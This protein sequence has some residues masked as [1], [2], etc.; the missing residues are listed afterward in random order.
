MRIGVVSDIHCNAAALDAALEAMS[1]TVEEVLVA[2]D[3][4]YEYRYSNEVV[5]TIRD[6]GF[7]C[8]LGNHEMVLLSPHGDRARSAEGVDQA[9]VAWMGTWP[10]RLDLRIGGRR[11]T[12]VHASPWEPYDRYLSTDDPTWRRC[13]ELDADILI[14]GHTHVPMVKSIGGTLV[15]NPGSLGESREPGRRELVSYAA[16][17][18]SSDAGT[19]AVEIVRFPNPRMAA[20]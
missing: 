13:A 7:P 10:K 8:I 11:I 5:S 2:G 16:I 6:G 1:D 3:V 4:V 12:M 18:L 20:A 14:T 9:G 17:D 19:D 15:V